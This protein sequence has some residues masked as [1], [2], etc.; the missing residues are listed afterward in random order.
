QMQGI[1]EWLPA[2]V[3]VTERLSSVWAELKDLC[4]ELESLEAAVSLDA[5][6]MQELQERMDLGYRLFK[7]HG[8]SDTAGL[9]ALQAR[10]T[11]ELQA[12]LNVADRIEALQ[13]EQASLL[14]EVQ[15]AA[16][17]LSEQRCK[18]A[19]GIAAEVT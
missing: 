3:P 5:G 2:S 17:A 9:M 6:L 14:K 19:P 8:V 18:V 4:S 16:G 7:K 1:G 10:L 11:E 12:S 15:A 13:G